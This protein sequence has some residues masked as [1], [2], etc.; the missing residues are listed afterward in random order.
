MGFD[1]G[2][3]G[4]I[5]V[6]LAVIAA[7]IAVGTA[8]AG[9]AVPFMS[10][11]VFTA[12]SGVVA[13]ASVF[14][15][16]TYMNMT[17]I[18]QSAATPDYMGDA[19]SFGAGA[20]ESILVNKASNN[21]P[22]PVIYGTRRVGGTRVF[23]TTTG[24]NNEYIW[25]VVVL[26][27]G[28]VHA[29]GDVYLD[30][31]VS[32]DSKFTGYVDVYKHLGADDQVAEPEMVADID[33]WT[34]AH[35]LQGTAYV[36]LR[37]KFNRDVFAGLPTITCNVSGIMPYDPRTETSAFSTNPALCIRDFLVNPRYG[38]GI[39]EES[40][41]DDSIEVA[42]DH[43]EEQVT[44]AGGEQDRYTCSGVVDTSLSSME[45]LKKLLTSCRGCMVFSGGK[46]QLKIDKA[47]TAGF[48]FDESNIIGSWTIGL[49]DKSSVINRV[50]A[51]FFNPD[52]EWQADI[53]PKDFPAYRA[54]DNGVLL[55]RDIELPFTANAGT[56]EQIA[57][58]CA[59]Q[60]RQ[61]IAVQFTATIA[62]MACQVFEV[63]K[64]THTTPG[65]TEKEFRILSLG[66]K[67]NGEVRVMLLEYDED[68]YDF[69]TIDAPD[70]SP[71]TNLPDSFSLAP[72]TDLTIVESAYSTRGAGTKAKATMT[73][74][75][76]GAFT[77]G[78]EWQYKLS[79]DEDWEDG[80]SSSV[81]VGSTTG[82][83]VL[84]DMAVGVYDFRV[85]GYTGLGVSSSYCT[86]YGQEIQGLAAAPTSVLGLSGH[87]L[88]DQF[89]VRWTKATDEDV[90]NGGGVQIRW[91]P[92]LTGAVWGNT[93][94]IGDSIAGTA[95]STVLPLLVGTYMFK[96]V[97]KMG[98]E[99]ASAVSIIS[100]V[101]VMHKMN[102]VLTATQDDT[103]PGTKDNMEVDSGELI[104]T[105][106]SSNAGSYIFSYNP[107][108]GAHEYIDLGS[109]A[110]PFNCRVMG[111]IKYVGN[112]LSAL[113]DDRGMMDDWASFDD[114]SDFSDIRAKLYA[115]VTDDDPS[116]SPD[117]SE[118][119]EFTNAD[120]VCRAI[121][122]KLEVTNGD[123]NHQIQISDLS[124]TIDMPDK[125]QGEAGVTLAAG[126]SNIT[127]DN[128]FK[129]LPNL[130]VTIMNMASGDYFTITNKATTGFTI[131]AF[132][133]T[134]TGVARNIN[135]SADG[136][137]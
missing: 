17:M 15:T 78:F 93:S 85:K 126:G 27:E 97:D 123:A 28:E 53:I 23:I 83:R 46:Y 25:V 30:D 35:R 43:C 110:Q 34:T 58:I 74:I 41:D 117:W 33:E 88:G 125:T 109:A 129:A 116:D 62:A 2:D 70:T 92:L 107:G 26:G 75:R 90:L 122:I 71:N 9:A 120:F 57:I 40:I 52:K 5:F 115:A 137:F 73:C 14:A 100:N 95:T 37:L 42:A 20:A 77:T 101:P 1:G 39:P 114:S 47:E 134:A 66:L 32:T 67:N 18:G 13:G 80:G 131:Q 56:A 99:S 31:T 118:W 11:Y 7:A 50:L 105:D 132:D 127:Y 84:L 3:G 65:W 79:S 60:S 94:P 106:P 136:Y 89:H 63:V 4:N 91:S 49:G 86:V 10:G 103:F 19:S 81:P 29:I 16:G 59:K 96:F 21:A 98:V 44:I 64:L 55:E 36:A 12:F 54:L 24:D 87:A 69:G 130:W 45:N 51:N 6:E 68:V 119:V 133:S 113:I 82:S 22:I 112:D 72:P 61:Q 121:K 108:D 135:W 128:E 124:V 111:S 38:R 8:T 102:F 104:M 48:V 76:G